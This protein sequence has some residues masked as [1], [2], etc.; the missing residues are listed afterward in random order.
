MT[1]SFTIFPAI[2]LRG[3]KVVRLAQGDPERETNYAGS[4][5]QWAERWKSEG[6][7]W[8][9][10][11]DLDGAFGKDSQLNLQALDSILG[12]GLKIEYGGGI[13][14]QISVETMVDLGVRRVFLGTAAVLNLTL[15]DWAIR[16]YG[17]AFI[18]G[19]IGALDGRVTIRGWQET[20]VL[21]VLEVG[22]LFL[23][24]GMERCVLTDVARDGVN[25][26]V[27]IASAVELQ[28][29]TGLQVV[30]SGG[31]NSLD[32]V[33]RVH[34]AGLAGVIIGRALYENRMTFAECKIAL[35]DY[36]E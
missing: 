20:T 33:Q 14:D 34:Q 13:R 21:T 11:V 10:I 19:D 28:K 9:H 36:D 3:G 4:P 29:A 7:D 24:H 30:A 32:D 6:A 15:V 18:A 12:L 22:H 26:G 5:L 1:G 8:I 27:N 25:A 2:D 16:T 17:P 31:V 23:S 35:G